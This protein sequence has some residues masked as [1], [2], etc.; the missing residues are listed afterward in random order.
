MQ[1][2]RIFLAAVAA[3]ALAAG[4]A[5]GL[6]GAQ[7]ANWHEGYVPNLPVLTQDGKSLNFYDDL[8]KGKIVVD[9]LH[10]YELP[11]CMSAEHRAHGA[12]RGEARQ[13]D[14]P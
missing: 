7:S 2:Q 8:I 13:A 9:Q 4:S 1:K 3:L 6:R 5:W 10:L 11:R 12:D 14:G